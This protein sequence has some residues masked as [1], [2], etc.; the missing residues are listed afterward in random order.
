MKLTKEVK[1]LAC[2]LNEESAH[3]EATASF[4]VKLHSYLDTQNKLVVFL[5]SY[6]GNFQ[7]LKQI[8]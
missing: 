5:T 4:V 8:F 7:K 6:I 3:S 1:Y 2:V